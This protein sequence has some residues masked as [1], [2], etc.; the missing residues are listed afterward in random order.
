MTDRRWSPTECNCE[1]CRTSGWR[2]KQLAA[3]IGGRQVVME[4]GRL[5]YVTVLA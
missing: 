3:T 2:V 1:N 4:F 5:A